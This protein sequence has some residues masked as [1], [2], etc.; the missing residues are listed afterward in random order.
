MSEDRSLTRAAIMLAVSD[1]E[2]SIAFCRDV[3]GFERID[4]PDI[5]LLRLGDLQLFL[6]E[7][8]SAAPDRRRSRS[9]RPRT[10]DAF[11]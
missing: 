11:P 10:E 1:I 8:S 3:L 9:F 2:R 7:E 5:P 6:V 4:Y